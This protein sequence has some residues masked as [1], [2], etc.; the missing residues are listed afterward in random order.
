MA[1]TYTKTA[2]EV[3]RRRVFNQ[4]D[5]WGIS[6]GLIRLPG[7]G[8]KDYKAR[9]LDVF[10]HRA[11]ST[12]IGLIHGLTRELG[13]EIYDALEINYT[14]SNGNAGVEVAGCYLKL[15][16]DWRVTLAASINMMQ[17]ET[18]LVPTRVLYY[19]E[20]VNAINAVPDW[21]ASLQQAGADYWPASQMYEQ[22]NH[23]IVPSELVPS[24]PHF[25]LKHYPV[26]D[27]T[28]PLTSYAPIYFSDIETF[29][30]Q[31]KKTDAASVTQ[32]GDWYLDA[33]NGVVYSY[34][35]SAG[36]TVRYQYIEWPFTLKASPVEVYDLMDSD[37]L[38]LLFKEE[39]IADGTFNPTDLTALGLDVN[40]ELK[41]IGSAVIWGI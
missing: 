11:N 39:A 22:A 3:I 32:R 21:S 16:T 34:E 24:M 26:K 17:Y 18:P 28:P 25:T 40:N 19:Y 38:N 6:L 14:G 33:T 4:L 27:Y 37:S 7:E 12:F 31:Q 1:T 2:N 10:A 35:V 30:P 41:S 5:E 9:L 15:W 23:V 13:F 20:V 8:N 36:S 29:N